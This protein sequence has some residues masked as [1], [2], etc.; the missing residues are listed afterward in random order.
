[1]CKIEIEEHVRESIKRIP[2]GYE[3]ENAQMIKES[4]DLSHVATIV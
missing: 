4:Y 3:S 2:H 1:M